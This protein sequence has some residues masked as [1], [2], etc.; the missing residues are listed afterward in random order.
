MNSELEQKLSLEEL[1]QRN[2]NHI[3][4]KET[5]PTAKDWLELTAALTAIGQLLAEHKIALEELTHQ[6]HL[7]FIQKQM[8]DL[9]QESKKIRRLME[10]AGKKK[11]RHFSLP[12]WRLP[13]PSL[14]WLLVLVPLL[15]LLVLW[16]SSVTLWNGIMYFHP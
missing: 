11:E 8:S 1:K 16:Y 5:H 7:H 10:Q 13:R 15:T 14:K 4:P 12:E 3:P 2:Q 9:I 6:Q